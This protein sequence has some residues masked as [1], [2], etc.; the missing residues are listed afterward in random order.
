MV[1]M[2]SSVSRVA[3]PW[4]GCVCHAALNRSISISRSDI[5]G[6]EPLPDPIQAH[7]HVRFRHAGNVRD[8][9]IADV[10]EIERKQRPV[11]TVERVYEL[12]EDR[13]LAAAA[14]RARRVLA[15]VDV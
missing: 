13:E 6:R 14:R 12:V 7:A 9:A 4:R 10:L 2:T 15:V 8:L 5:R 11:D 3:V 1:L